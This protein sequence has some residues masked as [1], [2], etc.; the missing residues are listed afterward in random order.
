MADEPKDNPRLKKMEE[1]LV[2]AFVAE[3]LGDSDKQK[4]LEHGFYELAF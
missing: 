4:K 3:T 2:Q 1:I